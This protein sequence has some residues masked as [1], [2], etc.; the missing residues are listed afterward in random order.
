MARQST[1]PGRLSLAGG[2]GTA[3]ASGRTTS[4]AHAGKGALAR[5]AGRS[6]AAPGGTAQASYPVVEPAAAS[7][8]ALGLSG[9]DVLYIVL[10]GVVLALTGLL[11]RRIARAGPAPG[12]R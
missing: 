11:T 8:P 2:S 7:S 9:S 3:A 12:D 5:G 6:G 10:A 1:A 4:P